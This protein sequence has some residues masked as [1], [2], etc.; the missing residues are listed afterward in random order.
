MSSRPLC[1]FVLLR[2][3]VGAAVSCSSGGPTG[4]YT[5]PTPNEPAT[6]T[7]AATVTAQSSGDGYGGSTFSFAPAVASVLVNGTVTWFNTSG[8]EHTITFPGDEAALGSGD[9]VGKTFT[10]AGSFAYSCTIH[11]GMGGTVQVTAP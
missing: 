11:P 2:L 5:P 8:T 1:Q 9:Q 6:P 7:L 3:G 4:S 10:A